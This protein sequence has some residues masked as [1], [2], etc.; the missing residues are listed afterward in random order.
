MDIGEH[1]R[2]IVVEPKPIPQLAPR[3]PDAEPAIPP[4]KQPAQSK[5]LGYVT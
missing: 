4:V 3:Q 2:V 1:K 5:A